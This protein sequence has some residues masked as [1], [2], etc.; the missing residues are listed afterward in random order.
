MNNRLLLFLL[1]SFLGQCWPFTFYLLV[2]IFG[3]ASLVKNH[4]LKFTGV[5]FTVVIFYLGWGGSSFL[6]CLISNL[7]MNE[8][9]QVV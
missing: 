4:V 2:T 6:N 7:Y 5:T 9:F 1:Q 3:I 8:L